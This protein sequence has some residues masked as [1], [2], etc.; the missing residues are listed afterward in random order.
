M[1]FF[2]QAHWSGM[3][4]HTPGDLPHPGIEP[5]SPTLQSD[6]LSSEPSDRQES[7]FI[8]DTFVNKETSV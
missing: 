3:P 1:E 6:S 8:C 4:F 2:R 7:L 5:S